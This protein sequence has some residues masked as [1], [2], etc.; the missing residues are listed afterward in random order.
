MVP[1]KRMNET[2][3]AT[4]NAKTKMCQRA[5]ENLHFI[6]QVFG[7]SKYLKDSMKFYKCSAYSLIVFSNAI[8]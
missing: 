3:A 6:L 8:I 7:H 1:M 2:A 4:I 5:E